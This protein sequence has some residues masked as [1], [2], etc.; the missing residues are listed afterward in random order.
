MGLSTKNFWGSLLAIAG[1]PIAIANGMHDA[2]I[3]VLKAVKR[4][5]T[6]GKAMAVFLVDTSYFECVCGVSK[7]GVDPRQMLAIATVVFAILQGR[8]DSHL[9]VSINRSN[10]HYS[11]V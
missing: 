8:T 11:G 7:R 4:Q 5:H 1:I 6:D 2:L 10:Y 9:M 3:R